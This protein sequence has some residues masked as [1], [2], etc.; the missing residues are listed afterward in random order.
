MFLAFYPNKENSEY[1]AMNN[2]VYTA[3]FFHFLTAL[4]QI[5]LFHALTLQKPHGPHNHTNELNFSVFSSRAACEICL[6]KS[7]LRF[8]RSTYVKTYDIAN[9]L[10]GLTELGDRSE[11]GISGHT[12]KTFHCE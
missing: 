12:V 4:S 3:H 7:L 10:L 11:N 6:Y 8:L 2:I 9:L 1:C 5:L